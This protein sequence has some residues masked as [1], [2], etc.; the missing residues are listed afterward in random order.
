VS[1]E[2]E[3]SLNLPKK[4]GTWL[5][6]RRP[7]C[8]GQREGNPRTDHR[9]ENISTFKACGLQ[10]FSLDCLLVL[11]AEKVSGLPDRTQSRKGF[12]AR[13]AGAFSLKDGWD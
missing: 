8:F 3:N 10:L 6:L 2:I 12:T 4:E 5:D 11:P 13:R 9:R 1:L 7:W